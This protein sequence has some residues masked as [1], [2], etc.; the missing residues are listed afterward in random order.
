MALKCC[1]HKLACTSRSKGREAFS[2]RKNFV[3]GVTRGCL[4]RGNSTRV[5]EIRA[6]AQP[7]PIK[8]AA[9]TSI[10]NRQPSR[11]HAS[12]SCTLQG[13]GFLLPMT[14]TQ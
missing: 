14:L 11:K 7:G 8:G 6:V 13:P 4:C 9:I 2:T 12:P 3:R 10:D 5:E 1:N